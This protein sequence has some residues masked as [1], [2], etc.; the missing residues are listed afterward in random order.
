MVTTGETGAGGLMRRKALTHTPTRYATD[1][2]DLRRSTGDSAQGSARTHWGENGYVSMHNSCT[3]P[4]P[5]LHDTGSQPTEE[6]DI[7]VESS[8]HQPL[9]HAARKCEHEYHK[10]RTVKLR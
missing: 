4:Y 10:G 1:G 6:A 5:K 8:E 9:P 3:L 2:K 7:Q